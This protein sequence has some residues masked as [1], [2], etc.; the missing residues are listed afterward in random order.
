MPR[1]TE[2]KVVL[3]TDK[4][5]SKQWIYLIF[6]KPAFI[7]S[8]QDFIIIMD[9][10]TCFYFPNKFFSWNY[11][12]AAPPSYIIP[13]NNLRLRQEGLFRQALCFGTSTPSFLSLPQSSVWDSTGQVAAQ[14]CSSVSRAPLL[15]HALDS[16][17][18]RMPCPN[19]QPLT[20][21]F[22]TDLLSTLS[23]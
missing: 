2:E 8:S 14:R 13:I 16:W 22:F 7:I 5:E 10:L 15:G 17:D 9:R 23:S 1:K 6:T 18:S 19:D 11:F 3:L 20:S 12:I 21:R 4:N